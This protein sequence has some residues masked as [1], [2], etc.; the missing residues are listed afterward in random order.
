M[1][2]PGEIIDAL[3]ALEVSRFKLNGV[4]RSECDGGDVQQNRFLA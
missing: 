4:G 1:Q 2:S 3:E